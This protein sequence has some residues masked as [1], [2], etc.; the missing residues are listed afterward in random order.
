M[1]VDLPEI[2]SLVEAS[3]MF[4]ILHIVRFYFSSAAFSSILSPSPIPDTCQQP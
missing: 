2:E 1:G 4:D 3:F